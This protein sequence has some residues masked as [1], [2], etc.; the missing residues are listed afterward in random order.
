MWL[1][2]FSTFIP[3]GILLG[4]T[5][6]VVKNWEKKQRIKTEESNDDNKTHKE[7]EQEWN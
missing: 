4:M 1:Y 6:G 5:N 2:T 3:K 7:E